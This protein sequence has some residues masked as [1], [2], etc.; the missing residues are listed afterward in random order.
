MAVRVRVNFEVPRV[1]PAPVGRAH[2]RTLVRRGVR[3]TLREEGVRGAEISITLLGDDEISELNQRFLGHEGPTDVISFALHD[4]GQ[5]PLGDIY[6]GWDQALRQAADHDEAP[7]AE[8]A[9]LAIH[10][11]LHVLG[12]DHP[13]GTE[14]ERSSMWKRQEEIFR[15]VIGISG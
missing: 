6:I 13:D 10:G 9:R 5:A 1:W 15:K 14:R 12:Y 4:Q 2:L 3:A 7:A 8:L 11:T